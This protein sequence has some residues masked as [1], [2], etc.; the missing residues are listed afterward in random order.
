MPVKI[1]DDLPAA[2]TLLDENIFVMKEGRAL[3]QDIRPLK[4][5]ILNLMPTKIVTETQILRLI[6]NTA[7]QVDVV[8]LHPKS[9]NSKTTPQE[10]LLTFYRSFS[11]VR[12]ETFDGLI[13]T[14]APVEHL[15]FE[16][17]DYWDELKEIMDWKLHNVT[18]TL[19]ICWAAQAGLYHH[20][21]IPKYDVGKKIFG[22]YKH[23]I[24]RKNVKLLRGF[25]DSFH[26]PHSRYTEVA[27]DIEKVPDLE[28]LADPRG[29]RVYCCLQ[30]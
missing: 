9:H 21:G 5:G 12:N 13:I 4:I 11:D 24:T 17:V 19:H 1:P 28:I 6:G 14:G 27:E 23:S 3:T 29:R 30:G 2:Q 26:V 18:S 15:P 10:H 8:L 20:Y 16:E 7:L 25:D 22:V